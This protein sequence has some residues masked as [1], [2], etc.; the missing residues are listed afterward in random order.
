MVIGMK[1]GR[2]KVRDLAAKEKT[3]AI[4]KAFITEFLQQIHGPDRF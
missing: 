4:A 2:T 3:C 1:Y